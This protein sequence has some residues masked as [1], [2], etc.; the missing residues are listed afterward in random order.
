M[1]FINVFA[2]IAILP[3]AAG[4]NDIKERLQKFRDP[5]NIKK[6]NVV[7]FLNDRHERRME[8][9]EEMLQDRRLQLEHHNSGR[10]RLSSEDHERV[11][12]QAV[13]YERK[14]TQMKNVDPKE[15]AQNM[16]IEA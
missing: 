10:R 14:L 8:K 2:I 9:L 11:S 7:K 6:E 16:E 13:N 4:A 3:F 12:R 5:K 15:H 1:K